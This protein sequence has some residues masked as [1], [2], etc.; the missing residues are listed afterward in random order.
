MGSP[1]WSDH[2]QDPVYLWPASAIAALAIHGVG[3]WGWVVQARST[4]SAPPAVVELVTLTEIPGTSAPTVASENMQTET[5]QT[6]TEALPEVSLPTAMAPDTASSEASD[7]PTLSSGQPERAPSSASPPAPSA[8]PP[9]RPS[10]PPTP[11]SSPTPVA[12]ENGTGSG[13]SNSGSNSNGNATAPVGDGVQTR[14]G[15]DWIPEARDRPD[16][17]P[18]LPPGWQ[19]RHLRVTDYPQCLSLEL[20]SRPASTTVRLQLLVDEEGRILESWVWQSSGNAAYD[21]AMQCIVQN[22]TQPLIPAMVAGTPILSDAA[23]L[24]IAGV[25]AP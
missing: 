20:L 7:L 8:S 21:R 5:E 18:Q 9:P 12:P 15:I 19:T 24:E 1:L 3:L 22:Q 2:H 4:T 17:L 13:N 11:G 6:G 25:I 23:L 14:W 10:K 16:T